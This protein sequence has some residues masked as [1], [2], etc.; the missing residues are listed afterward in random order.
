MA[1]GHIET[2]VSLS[3][4]TSNLI[5]VHNTVITEDELE[6]LASVPNIWF[7][8][9]PSSNLHISGKMPPVELL[10]KASDVLSP[11]LTASPQP[12]ILAYWVSLNSCKKLHPRS[13]LMKSY[14]GGQ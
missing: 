14:G 11:E 4:L 13:R 5:L 9:C 8:L 10:A 7:C 6:K 3:K 12:I 1:Q 2:A